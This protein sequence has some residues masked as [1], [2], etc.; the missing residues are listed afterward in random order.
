[1]RCASLYVLLIVNLK[2]VPVPIAKDLPGG[3]IRV[4][5]GEEAEP[6]L[7]FRVEGV[8]PDHRI[9]AII[10]D[11]PPFSVTIL[12]VIESVLSKLRDWRMKDSTDE[13]S[14]L[15]LFFPRAPVITIWLRWI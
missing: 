10:T 13:R 11:S 9:V 7:H 4:E 3:F 14:Y 1:M 8:V 12:N 5:C 15:D 6:F 2:V